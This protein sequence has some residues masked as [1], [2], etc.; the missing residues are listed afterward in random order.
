MRGL[1]SITVK[2]FVACLI[3]VSVS[4][5][6]TAL[7]SRAL[8]R[9]YLERETVRTLARQ[10]H[11][12]AGWFGLRQDR[13]RP[14]EPPPGRPFLRF[15]GRSVEA[16][17]VVTDARGLIVASSLP[18]RFPPNAPLWQ[19]L[20]D[21]PPPPPPGRT[22]TWDSGEYLL[23][24]A[25]LP[26]GPEARGAVAVLATRSALEAV[27]RDF[28]AIF[29]KSLGLAF[30]IAA[31]AAWLLARHILRP[32]ALLREQVRAVARRRFDARVDLNTDDE[33]A[34]L[35]A[36]FN[37]MTARLREH[38]AAM[39]R[40]LQYASHELKTP[41]TSIQ[42]YAEG[43]RDGVFAGQE[44]DHAAEVIARESQRLR[45]TV[46]DI[47]YLSRLEHPGETYAREEVDLPELLGEVAEALGG[48]ALE[49]KVRVEVEVPAGLKMTGDREK[50]RRL[51]ANVLANAI[52]HARGRVAVRAA[53]R[54]DAPAVRVEFHDDGPGFEPSRLARVFEPFYR[55]PGGGTGLGL[56]IARAVAEGHGGNIAAAN[57]PGGGGLVT[58][59]LP[60]GP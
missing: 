12:M 43:I 44:A 7:F 53:Y 47:I 21:L 40:F 3:A 19:L 8:V 11:A 2:I 9:Q 27:N 45:S 1:R 36:A 13:E 25:G 55:G 54:P 49:R 35:A 50:L 14:P 41:L 59:T 57:A 48:Y 4:T 26:E 52:R 33:L 15:P 51:F 5:A 24:L 20:P 29:L 16:D 32:L 42:G 22:V 58:V 46:E 38:D 17:Y 30:V 23:A 31:A 28:L 34:E 6:A 60:A 39:R 10:A 37:E 56:A 18:D